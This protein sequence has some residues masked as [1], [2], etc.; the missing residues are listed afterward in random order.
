MPSPR[1]VEILLIW[2]SA[3]LFRPAALGQSAACDDFHGTACS[4]HHQT[5]GGAYDLIQ[6]NGQAVRTLLDLAARNS[7]DSE[8]RKPGVFY[9]ACMHSQMV[10][11]LGN[12]YPELSVISRISSIS[13]LVDEVAS[14]HRIG[15]PALFRFG[16][17]S[18]PENPTVMV[19]GLDQGGLGLSQP[20]YYFGASR[21]LAGVRLRYM[22]HLTAL[23]SLV[24]DSREDANSEAQTAVEIETELA[25]GFGN[26]GSLGRASEA[27]LTRSEAIQLAPRLMLDG[28]FAD[29]GAPPFSTILVRNPQFFVR[30]NNLLSSIPLEQWKSYLRARL[31]RSAAPYLSDSFS[32]EYYDFERTLLD[33]SIGEEP[34]WE[35]C[36]R[37]T[38]AALPDAVGQLFVPKVLSPDG[39]HQAQTIAAAV[40]Q[41]MQKQVESLA[42]M[43]PSAKEIARQKIA[44]I[45]NK[46]GYPDNW[47]DYAGL[48][49][50]R[51]DF[52]G[53]VLRARTYHYRQNLKKIG[54][55][56][57][58]TEW[59]V[60]VTAVNAY[61]DPVQNN[62]TVPAGLLQ[63][64]VFYPTADGATNFGSLG[65]AIAHEL[66]HGVDEEGSNYDADHRRRNWWTPE[67]YW[68][69]R[70][71]AACFIEQYKQTELHLTDDTD[72]RQ[73]NAFWTASENIAD[74]VGLRIAL[75]AMHNRET[76][77]P[78]GKINGLTPDQRFFLAYARMWCGTEAARTAGL[79][80]VHPANEYRV[81][82]V[83][84]NFPEFQKAFA[85]KPTDKMVSP[86]PCS[87]W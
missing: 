21:A 13:A 77:H 49:I 67:D 85:C 39:K 34:R 56:V 31:I 7:D 55:P 28:Y 16:E 52:L 14:L 18:D 69:F 17:V 81:D 54:K 42:W 36:V 46:I 58:K 65:A 84:Q 60:P 80:D 47:D 15:I 72:V 8:F 87:V 41:A 11:G 74:N 78:T 71:R 24:G 5:P 44:R 66:S 75:A 3:F 82:G 40:E 59:S 2:A 70:N 43:S 86:K 9:S 22:Q 64:P 35:R 50:R 33:G 30:L 20:G 12:A 63:P 26:S 4:K 6:H 76:L 83:L 37:Y 19:A 38:E 51:D 25:V 29:V 79:S 62:I 53:N 32:N 48:E 10:S 1:I 23:F 45:T 27:I 73:R 68:Q 57:D 61:Y